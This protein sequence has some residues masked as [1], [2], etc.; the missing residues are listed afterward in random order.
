MKQI[1]GH[2]L[3]LLLRLHLLNKEWIV[4]LYSCFLS[5]QICIRLILWEISYEQTL[6]EN[7]QFLRILKFSVEKIL[8]GNTQ[9]L[10][11]SILIT[12]LSMFQLPIS[13]NETL[14]NTSQ[15]WNFDAIKEPSFTTH[16][17]WLLIIV[18]KFTLSSKEFNTFKRSS[19]SC[20]FFK[21]FYFIS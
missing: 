18:L 11:K 13:E 6:K 3:V 10:K 15:S 12:L 5:L 1:Y 17:I 8:I 19:S 16:L 7:G 20:A 14:H 2:S 4:D 9:Y 21:P